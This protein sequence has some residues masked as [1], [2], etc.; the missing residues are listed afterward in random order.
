MFKRILVMLVLMGPVHGI[1][2]NE[3]L[4]VTAS[5]VIDAV[6]VFT[7]RA[8]VKRVFSGD[9]PEG[10]IT[11]KIPDLPPGMLN[12]SVRVSGKGT[13]GAKISGVW[14]ETEYFEEIISG[15]I[16]SLKSEL[17]AF[18]K[19]EKELLD[20]SEVLSHKQRFIDNISAKA[21]E[22]VPK[23][24][25]AQ[26][27]TAAEWAEMV[28]FI[29]IELDKINTEK[30]SI[31]EEKQSIAEKKEIITNQLNKYRADISNSSK[32]V[33]VELQMENPGH[34]DFNLSYIVHGATWKPVYDIRAE[35]DADTIDMLMFAE[36]IQNT[37]ENWDNVNVELSTARPSLSAKPLDPR[38]WVIGLR[39]YT[40]RFKASGGRSGEVA[41]MLG[42]YSTSSTDQ[43]EHPPVK[44]V[45]DVLRTTSGFVSQ[46]IDTQWAVSDVREM[47]IST[48]FALAQR[49]N[50]PGNNTPKKVSVKAVNMAGD[51]EYFANP[52]Q[53]PFAYLKARLTNK[54]N[55]PFLQGVASV[56]L[57]GNFVHSTV[58]PM[59]VPKEEFDLYLGIDD[60]IKINRV[61]VEKFTDE[62]GMLSSK[63]KL[64]YSYKITI[65]NFKKARQKI[66]VLDQYPVSQIDQI[67][68]K[69]LAASPE[70]ETDEFDES[71]GFLRWVFELEPEQK[72]E[73]NFAYEI[74]YPEN[75]DIS[76]LQ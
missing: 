60:K 16:K 12:E 47:M 51:T 6:T 2:A 55:F 42:G 27:P 39:Q 18:K 30:R 73:I 9:F 53:G 52:R 20:R 59:V 67:N 54:T 17:E 69:L 31:E 7:D 8:M 66:T 1:S 14:V 26:K 72:K 76:G 38:P 5:T 11:V 70:T 28:N 46:R 29:E 56:F 61:L 43:I 21:S 4:S 35:S 33:M 40:G 36:I 62:A 37:G 65:E 74:K 45:S 24:I 15:Q 32:T 57:D 44:N 63:D 3:A 68:V 41:P 48:S 71:K 75:Y 19:R 49:E 64:S 58:I 25:A 10:K 13:S 50:I 22:P 34:F 23:G